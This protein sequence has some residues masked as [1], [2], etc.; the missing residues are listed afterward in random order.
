MKNEMW[1]VF[2]NNVAGEFSLQRGT[3]RF[4]FINYARAGFRSENAYEHMRALQ[5]GR[6]IDSVYTDKDIFEVYLARNASA[7]LTFDEFVYPKLSVFHNKRRHL[8]RT[9][10]SF[11]AICSS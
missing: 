6:D 2:Q 1:C 5:V 3:M 10:Y 8:T 7:Q 11:C 9:P 4:Q